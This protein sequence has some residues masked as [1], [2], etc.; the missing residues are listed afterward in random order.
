MDLSE[1]SFERLNRLKEL[2]EASS[3]SE[4]MRDALRLYEFL[5]S[6]NIKGSVFFVESSSGDRTKIINL[7]Q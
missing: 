6:E 1:G 5:L 4:L 3:Y 7:F 2:T